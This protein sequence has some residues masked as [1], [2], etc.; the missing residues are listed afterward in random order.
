MNNFENRCKELPL[1]AILR[2]ITPPEVVSVSTVLIE[3][4][5]RII[6]V[7]LN[8]PKPFESI[9]TLSRMF[10]GQACVGAGTVLSKIQIDSVRD[11]GGELIV[12]PHANPHLVRYAKES[13][14]ACVPGAATPTEAFTMFEAGAD[15]V[16]LFPAESIPPK[17]VKAWRAV[18]PQDCKLFPV[19]GIVP[20]N[21]S[22][23]LSAGVNGFG[24]GSALYKAGDTAREVRVTANAFVQSYQAFLL[25]Q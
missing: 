4:G 19:G 23:Y 7:P 25:S 18:L 5:F 17:V 24:L 8:S 1:I 16:K 11:A 9:N 15:A 22:L 12:M 6:E 10:G 3:V 13:G 14:L 2:G 21:Q 20:E